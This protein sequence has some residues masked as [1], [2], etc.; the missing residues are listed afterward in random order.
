MT[1]SVLAPLPRLQPAARSRPHVPRHPMAPPPAAPAPLR[2]AVL[3]AGVFAR[4][5]WAS[6]LLCASGGVGA[7]PAL[8]LDAGGAPR[9]PTAA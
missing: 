1:A 4:D 3:G 8:H 7:S 5:A 6:V 2:L 9:A